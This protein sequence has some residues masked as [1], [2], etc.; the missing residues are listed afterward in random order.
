[1]EKRCPKCGGQVINLDTRLYYCE[2]CKMNT[3]CE[4]DGDIGYSRQDRYA[5]RKEEYELRQKQRAQRNS[6]RRFR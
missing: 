1:M 2:N 6:K 3:D 5:E 4:D